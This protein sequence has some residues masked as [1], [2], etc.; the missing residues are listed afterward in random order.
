M[1][2]SPPS[3]TLC[4]Q[5]QLREYVFESRHRPV[6]GEDD[7]INMFPVVKHLKPTSTD[8]TRL[9]QQAQ[10]AVQQGERWKHKYKHDSRNHYVLYRQVWNIKIQLYPI[11]R[12]AS[13]DTQL[14]KIH[15]KSVH[16]HNMQASWLC[17]TLLPGN[18]NINV[19]CI[20][21]SSS[22]V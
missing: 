17:R 9:V 22:D 21:P 13:P 6:F 12:N 5:V 18:N 14:E 2:L 20:V 8:A 15:L 11:I 16:F 10:L 19:H 1:Y 4:L 3:L 7:I